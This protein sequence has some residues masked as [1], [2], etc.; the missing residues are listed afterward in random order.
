MTKKRGQTVSG[1]RRQDEEES[2]CMK[3]KG[4]ESDKRPYQGWLEEGEVCGTIGEKKAR[5]RGA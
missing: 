2:R 5:G 4:K 1:P 3:A